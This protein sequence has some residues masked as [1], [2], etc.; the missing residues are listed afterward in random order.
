MK[1][2][3]F[4]LCKTITEL[5]N[6]SLWLEVGRP[7]WSSFRHVSFICYIWWTHPISRLSMP[8]CIKVRLASACIYLPKFFYYVRL[9]YTTKSGVELSRRKQWSMLVDKYL[10]YMTKNIGGQL[11]DTSVSTKYLVNCIK[12]IEYQSNFINT[13]LVRYRLNCKK[14]EKVQPRQN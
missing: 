10:D 1:F 5:K 8:N 3:S 2:K 9:L 11:T 6:T 7:T 4:T 14:R 13:T 12:K